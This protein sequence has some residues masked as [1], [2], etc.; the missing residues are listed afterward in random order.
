VLPGVYEPRATTGTVLHHVVRTH[1][2]RLLTETAAA[3]DGARL[4]RFIGFARVPCDTYRFER[5]V[6]FSCKARAICSSCGAPSPATGAR[7]H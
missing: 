6:P 2:D 4:P 5:R 7:G 1:L 3:M